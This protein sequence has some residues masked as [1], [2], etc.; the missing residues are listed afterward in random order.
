MAGP[1]CCKAQRSRWQAMQG[2]QQAT[3]VCSATQAVDLRCWMWKMQCTQQP[4][5]LA[6][7]NSSSS[8]NRVLPAP[9]ST[10]LGNAP[11][12]QQWWPGASGTA[13]CPPFPHPFHSPSLLWNKPSPSASIITWLVSTFRFCAAAG[14]TAQQDVSTC[15][16]QEGGQ[17]GRHLP[18]TAVKVRGATGTGP[19]AGMANPS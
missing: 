3:A 5:E 1:S 12:C 8:N 14:A 15:E 18:A 7:R 9:V 17:G 11:C 6:C 10:C 16:P 2:P 4:V 13:Q 19:V